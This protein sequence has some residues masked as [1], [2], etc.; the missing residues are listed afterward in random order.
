MDIYRYKVAHPNTDTK[1]ITNQNE[2]GPFHLH[3]HMLSVHVEL[4]YLKEGV[5]LN[6]PRQ[7]S[8]STF[9]KIQNKNEN[10]KL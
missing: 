2:A 1:P 9:I 6:F 4:S 5:V 3:D 8:K 7:P 10:K